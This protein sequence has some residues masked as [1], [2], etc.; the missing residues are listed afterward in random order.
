MWW[1]PNVQ[2]SLAFSN[3][4]HYETQISADPKRAGHLIACAMMNRSEHESNNVFYVS[5]DHGR[6]WTHA[7][8]MPDSV[9]PACVIGP[10]GTAFAASIHDVMQPDGSSPSFLDV[11]RSADGAAPGK[12]RRFESI[13]AARTAVT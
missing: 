13:P 7:L 5:F 3:L 10:D 11:H 1:D 9:D 6:T 4:Q 12:S 2:V 8:T